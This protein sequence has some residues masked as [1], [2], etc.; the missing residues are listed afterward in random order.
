MCN[1]IGNAHVI[2]LSKNKKRNTN[3]HLWYD[4]NLKSSKKGTKN[5]RKKC[6]N[7]YWCSGQMPHCSGLSTVTIT[8][9]IFLRSCPHFHFYLVHSFAFSLIPGKEHLP[10]FHHRSPLAHAVLLL[11]SLADTIPWENQ[12]R[13]SEKQMPFYLFRFWSASK[14]EEPT[15]FSLPCLS[16][17]P[18][19]CAV[20]RASSPKAAPAR[21]PG[22]RD[23]R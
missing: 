18:G 22:Q 20:L 15:S 2:M 1:D 16:W 14:L 4:N 7:G 5:Q 17:R 21:G 10:R 9:Q 8:Q 12:L 19:A 11:A 23:P 6:N 13:K 3:L